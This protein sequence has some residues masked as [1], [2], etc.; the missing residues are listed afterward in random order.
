MPAYRRR[1]ERQ[2]VANATVKFC[3]CVMRAKEQVVFARFVQPLS[4]NICKTAEAWPAGAE[5]HGFFTCAR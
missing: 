1:A 3:L 5:A 2:G 4:T